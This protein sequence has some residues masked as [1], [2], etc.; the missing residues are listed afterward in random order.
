[1]AFEL[2]KVV[3]WGRNLKEYKAMFDLSEADLDKKMISFG[4][5]PASFN[6]ELDTQGR[7]CISI[8]PIY[9]FTKNE[10]ATRFEEVKNTVMQQVRDN[11]ANFVWK[12]IKDATEL[13]E[14]RTKSMSD[15]LIDFE[16]GKKEKRYVAHVL[17]EKLDFED[18]QFDIG[19]SSHFLILYP[20]LGLDFHIKS[21]KEMLRLCK[22]IRIFPILNLDA[23]KS[24]LLENIITEFTKEYTIEINKVGYEFQKGGDKML[25]IIHK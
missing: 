4:D 9:Q 7:K 22:E 2:E 5:G 6:S 15:F 10:L 16:K 11:T 1:M 25:K 24:E 14:T 18:Q 8:D 13:E 19:L 17:P 23:E 21:I 3:P 12:N 20:N